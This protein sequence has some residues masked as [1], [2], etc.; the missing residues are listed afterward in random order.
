MSIKGI[1]NDTNPNSGESVVAHQSAGENQRLSISGG[2]AALLQS[3]GIAIAF[4]SYQ[5]G[6]L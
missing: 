4:T 6:L 3:L 2:L 5:S 1:A